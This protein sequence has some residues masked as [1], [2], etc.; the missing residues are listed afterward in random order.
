MMATPEAD[1]GRGRV[2]MY[3]NL[4]NLRKFIVSKPPREGYDALH[5]PVA[6]YKA[7]S[8]SAIL[9]ELIQQYGPDRERLVEY[10]DGKQWTQ[11]DDTTAVDDLE[12][13]CASFR[14]VFTESK[15]VFDSIAFI[16][17]GT[18]KP[19]KM[20]T[21]SD[22]G[23]QFI[24]RI[25]QSEALNKF[26]EMC[27][28]KADSTAPTKFMVVLPTGCGK[29]LVV[30]LAPFWAD[31]SKC[32]VVT[33]NK[34]IRDQVHNALQ[35]FYQDKHPI[36]RTGKVRAQVGTWE[37]NA[38]V[39]TSADLIVTNIQALRSNKR[40]SGTLDD[41][42]DGSPLLVLT[43][44]AQQLIETFK[45][46][47][48]IIDEGHHST[49]DSWNVVGEAVKKQSPAYITLM[50]TATPE[51]QDGQKYDLKSKEHYYLL[52]RK[53]AVVEKYIK[54]TKTI[55]IDVDEQTKYSDNT[56][57]QRAIITRAVKELKDLRKSL[58]DEPVRMLVTT[59]TKKLADKLAEFIN[60][61]S[62]TH[63]W[64]LNA[65]TIHGGKKTLNHQALKRFSCRRNDGAGLMIDI[66]VQCAMLGEG[67]DNPMIAI[68]VFVA[69]C[70]AVSKLA[71][72]HGRAV[73][74]P[75]YYSDK[76]GAP[77][78][79]MEAI[80]IYPGSQKFQEIVDQYMDGEDET[81][82][83]L[84]PEE[85]DHWKTFKTAHQ[86]ISRMLSA[87]AAD[88][89]LKHFKEYHSKY[90]SIR[91][92][93]GWDPIPAEYVADL[94]FDGR[95]FSAT[96]VIDF[97]II[98]LGCGRDGLFEIQAATNAGNRD[99][100][101]KLE[102]LAVDVVELEIA[103]KLTDQGASN[104]DAAAAG[105]DSKHTRFVCETIARNYANLD[106]KL[107]GEAAS[108]D[109][110]GKF[111]AAVFCLSFM[112]KDALSGGLVA[113][114]KLIKP[115]GSI[116]VVLDLSK[117]G[118][119]PQMDLKATKEILELWTGNFT[120]RTGFEVNNYH[121]HS[122]TGPAFVYM[123]LKNIKSDDVEG[124]ED[125]LKEVTLSSLRKY[126]E[127]RNETASSGESTC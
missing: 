122:T 83:Y 88:Y 82:K 43:D 26:R 42:G 7:K 113:A 30:A 1:T 37:C 28:T 35:N 55:A 89:L 104:G 105:V 120:H 9:S 127:P 114:A 58:I 3:P 77:V 21:V 18:N 126:V 17:P 31:A 24:L 116:Y 125:K 74:R 44:Q 5:G 111:D 94:I 12:T 91:E 123:Q 92:D 56:D 27:V 115:G 70:H 23:N 72:T 66:G 6:K 8:V 69:P 49:A 65:E 4:E 76:P 2:P 86:Q 10:F 99:S 103:E 47:L 53:K 100:D 84:F 54:S 22:F 45:P 68:S 78:R 38:Q 57:F 97:R 96:D 73:R 41:D 95:E 118:I 20:H 71:Q 124:L 62:K 110:Y 29:T 80:L 109:S 61:L 75:P 11:L 93:H 98:D 50:L 121:V 107:D 106:A 101:G 33:P 39:P 81:S 102:V 13:D 85:A 34:T 90:E 52:K 48:L 40:K 46:N 64:G 67:Y 25:P 15:T 60:R 87:K 59:K 19:K 16:N 117:F 119:P 14:I 32:L 63:T 36:G 112:S 51:R 108:F 79:T